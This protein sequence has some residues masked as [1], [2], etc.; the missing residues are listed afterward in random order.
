[1]KKNEKDEESING[2]YYKIVKKINKKITARYDKIKD[3][4][5]DPAGYFLI[6]LNRE[7]KILEVGYCVLSKQKD[8]KKNQMKAIIKGRTAIEVVNTLIREKFI[9][10]LQ[11]A[12]D[13]GIEL[14]K[15][16]V[17]LNYN[18]KYIQDKDLEINIKK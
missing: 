4:K 18:L 6:R 14:S 1:M 3:W 2:H 15:A 11:H 16:E 5:M 13:M 17:A 10:T 12:A 7:K 9:S 8:S